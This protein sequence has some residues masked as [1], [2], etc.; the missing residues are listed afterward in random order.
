MSFRLGA[1]FGTVFGSLG[2]FAAYETFQKNSFYW[3]HRDSDKPPPNTTSLPYTPATP[4]PPPPPTSN[5]K[6]PSSSILPMLSQ[7]GLPSEG[8]YVRY[9]STYIAGF[10]PL[11]RTPQWVLEYIT[12]ESVSSKEGNR[13]GSKFYSDET[14]PEMFRATNAD[15]SVGATTSG[16][17][18]G[19]LAAAQF[20]KD[21]QA[22]MNDTFNLSLN[23]V[24]QL[25]SMNGCDWFRLEQMVKK[26]SKKY[27]SMWVVTG[28]AM[29][30]KAQVGP[31]EWVVEYKLIG[32]H[33]V[34]VPTHMYKVIL[35]MTEA[36]EYHITSFLMPNAPIPQEKSLTHFQVPVE[37]IE[38]YTGLTF[39]PKLNT[40]RTTLP[41]VC[42]KNACEGSYGSFSHSYRQLS[43]IQSAT[44]KGEL[45]MIWNETKEKGYSDAFLTRA[46]ESMKNQ[47]RT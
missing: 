32:D 2:T 15:Y 8:M 29:L 42:S 43:R 7:F 21:S 6:T 41:N 26:L 31:K 39:F 5:Q 25:M 14:I 23:V 45:E 22:S 12:P 30:P 40:Q 20:H 37:E 13:E 10:S 46:Y 36:G 4:P 17:S 35:G 28:P 27:K 47:L 38:R 9:T 11:Y 1:V 33:K 24:P 3:G 18:R 19:H 44:S 34:A 16:L